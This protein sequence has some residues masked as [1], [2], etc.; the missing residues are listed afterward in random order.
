MS[1]CQERTDYTL[2]LHFTSSPIL[3][4]TQD[5]ESKLKNNT[6]LT[7]VVYSFQDLKE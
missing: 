4:R 6:E 7:S 5:S 3:K 2:V 1:T